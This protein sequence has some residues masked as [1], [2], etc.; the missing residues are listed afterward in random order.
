MENPE[1]EHQMTPYLERIDEVFEELKFEEP[2]TVLICEAFISYPL[3]QIPECVGR[4][5]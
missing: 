2:T 3:L 5:Y 4:F 1:L